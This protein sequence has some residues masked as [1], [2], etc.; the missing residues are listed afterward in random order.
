MKILYSKEVFMKRKS[1]Q[2][3][4][5]QELSELIRTIVAHTINTSVSN[6]KSF[7]Q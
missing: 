4:N 6:L 2:I 5:Q 1:R 7:I 3:T